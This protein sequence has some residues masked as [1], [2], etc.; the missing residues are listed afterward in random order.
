MQERVIQKETLEVFVKSL[1]LEEKSPAT[2]EKYLRDTRRFDRFAAGRTVNKELVIAY[3]RALLEQ[4]YAIR[5]VNSMLASVNSLL[6]FLGWTECEVKPCRVQQEVYCQE[7]K[8][9]TKAEYQRLLLAAQNHP[10]LHLVLETLCSTGI[11]VSELRFFTVE[12]ARRGE[13]MVRC[14][15]KA[16]HILLPGK[17]RQRLLRYAK[18]HGIFSGVIFCGRNGKPLH[19]SSIWARMKRL[20]KRAKVKESKVFPHNLRRLFARTFYRAERDIAKL[21]DLLGHSSVNTTRIYLMTTGS[22]HRRTLDRLGLVCSD[23]IT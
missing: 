11:R 10:Q 20:C 18:E 5:S 2:V 12:A 1:R 22:E 7:E 14:K 23:R 9:L 19:R 21:A 17:L 4:G 8:E 16:R 3:K 6:R 13:V 15:G